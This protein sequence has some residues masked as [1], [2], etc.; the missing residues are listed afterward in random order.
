MG[1]QRLL[2]RCRVRASLF[3]V[4][5]FAL[6]MNGESRVRTVAGV[7]LAVLAFVAAGISATGRQKEISTE[8]RQIRQEASRVVPDARRADPDARLA[9]AEAA[10]DAGRLYLAL[11]E[12][13][14]AFETTKAFG[15]V[16]E[17]SAVHTTADFSARWQALGSPAAAPASAAPS[18]P[19][20]VEALAA[21]AESRAAATY[22]A[23][24]P[25]A[26]DTNIEA[27]LYYLGESQAF[28]AFA[29]Y[30]RSIAWP[31]AGRAPRLRSIAPELEA[32]DAEVTSAY[33]RM[34]REQHSTYVMTSVTLK[35]ARALDES[36]HFGGALLE[37]LIARYRF[38]PLRPGAPADA[39]AAQRIAAERA[40]LEAGTDHSIARFFVEMAEAAAVREDASVRRA[41]AVIVDDVLP[42][43][44]RAIGVS[45]AGGK[46]PGLRSANAVT[47]T[48]VRWP[49]T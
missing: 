44:H 35:R 23:S 47:I 3:A 10:I 1:E 16:R 40:R 37:Y 42:A 45:N 19:L 32:L 39:P 11:F 27:G 5:R 14:G 24:L 48:L 7:G 29:S 49:Y 38:A 26:Q 33:E 34:T 31:S 21:S 18:I 9:R 25:Y 2:K 28:G 41:A 20:V 36:G 6:R 17:S 13:E 46:G 4:R 8:V 22:R 30:A 12:F 43:Y 15:F